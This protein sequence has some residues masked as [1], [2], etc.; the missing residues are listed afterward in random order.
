MADVSY[1]TSR[2]AVYDI[3]VDRHPNFFADGILV[4]NCLVI[5]DALKNQ[6]E[7]DSPV[8]RERIWDWYQSTALTRVEPGGAVFLIMTRW[9]ADDL[10]GRALEDDPNGWTVIDLPA[11]ADG[12]PDALDRPAGQALWPDVWDEEALAERRRAVGER[13]WAALYQQRP[14]PAG[15]AVFKRDWWRRYST[16]P[17]IADASIFVDSAFKDGVA[18]DYSAFAL[19]GR[20]D[21]DGYYLLDLWRERVQFPELVQAGHD[22]HARARAL[23]PHL[24]AVPLVVE[25]KAS[26][27]SAIQVWSRPYVTKDGL[28]LPKLPVIP[29]KVGSTSKVSRAEAVSPLVES[30]LVHLPAS[31]PWVGEFVEE[32]AAFPTG[33]HDD[34]VDTTSMG[35][36]RLSQ[37]RQTAVRSF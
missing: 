3:Q 29:W 1:R 36:A 20:T 22:F 28:R 5:D 30:G 33:V 15:G 9:H 18:S 12:G 26:G 14:S 17:H 4:H 16:I 11:I 8:I 7:A 34:M 10:V 37:R 13:A 23:L 31:A 35:L 27:Q 2:E 19:W 32:H 25:D 21:D 24:R 6:Q